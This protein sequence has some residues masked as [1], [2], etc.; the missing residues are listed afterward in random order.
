[1]IYRN[2][3][4]KRLISLRLPAVALLTLCIA[5]CASI[6]EKGVSDV[7]LISIV[8]TNDVHG[9]LVEQSDR[10]GL[11]TFSG[12]VE[13]LRAARAADGGEVLLI[14]GG[15]MWQGTLESNLSEGRFMVEA[16]NALGYVAAA[17]GNH[18]FDFGP[19]GPLSIPQG[20]H[21]DPQGALRQ[22][23]TEADFPLLAANIIDVSTERPVDWHNIQPSTMVNVAG[24]RI[25]I[26]GVMTSHLLET[27]ISANT[28]GLRVAPLAESIATEARALRGAGASLVIVTAHAGGRCESFND[29]LDLSSCDPS[30]EILQVARALP[31]GLVDHIIAGHVHEGIAHVVNDTSITSSYSNTRAFG[32]VDFTLDRKSGERIDRRVFPP[33]PLCSHVDSSTGECASANDDG[34]VRASYAG[35]LIE[36]SASITAIAER[37]AALAEEFNSQD[38]GVYLETPITLDGR[39]ESALGNLMTDAVLEMGVGDIAIHNVSGGIRANLP[40]GTLTY[41][42]VFRMFPFDNRIVKLSLSGLDLRRIIERQVHN[43]GRRAGFSGMRVFVECVGK[44]MSVTMLLP[45]GRE[46]KD[47]DR[48]EVIANDF[49]ALGGDDVLTPVMPEGGFVIQ[50]NTPLVRDM[51]A[52][53]FEARG[54]RLRAEQFLD[55]TRRR[56]NLP[57]S[58]PSGCAL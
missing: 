15:D 53:W 20:R 49:I 24:I 56:W 30:S 23:A 54:G 2:R 40:A 12:Y 38:L 42:S 11:T 29:P 36:P 25:G 39:D 57:D 17:L 21:D 19:V 22:R 55:P 9:E 3:I 45:D 51:L 44:Q 47:E 13:A 32:R 48:L 58:I 33:Q 34:A 18:E 26:V 5:A 4:R 37:A 31:E 52:G 35:R 8:A 41:G 43:A 50:T 46:I 1:M 16:Y 10:G 7:V 14:D 6:G 27:T 28:V